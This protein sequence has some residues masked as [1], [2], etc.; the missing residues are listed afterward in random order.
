VISCVVPIVSKI[1]GEWPLL[2]LRLRLGRLFRKD[3][4]P[5]I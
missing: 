4:I 1:I 3:L 2:L 5:N